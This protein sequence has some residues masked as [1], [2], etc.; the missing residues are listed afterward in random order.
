MS[1][2][3]PALC[4]FFPDEKTAY[5]ELRNLARHIGTLRKVT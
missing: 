5:A 1:G 3:K 4:T 2:K